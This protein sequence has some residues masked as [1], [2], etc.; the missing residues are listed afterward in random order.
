MRVDDVQGLTL[1][2]FSAQPKRLWL[3]TTE[4]TQRFPQKVLTL[5]RKVDKCKPLMTL[6]T[7]VC[8]ALNG[9]AAGIRAQLR[10]GV[11]GVHGRT[12]RVDPVKPMFTSPGAKRLKQKC[13][14]V[15]PS[16]AFTFNLRRYITY[17]CMGGG[18]L[19]EDAYSMGSNQWSAFLADCEIPDNR[20]GPTALTV[21][22]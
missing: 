21:C 22:S 10:R 11:P 17:F 15:L 19:G 8:Q 16:I 14:K 2:R 4:I 12:V 20:R 7:C 13:D 3:R 6:R 18:E 9:G 5:S 1:V